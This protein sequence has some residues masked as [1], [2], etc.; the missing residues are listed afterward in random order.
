MTTFALVPGAGGEAVYW[1]RV[2]PLL[3]AAG[4]RVVPVDLPADD[5]KAGWHEYADAVVTAV[6]G[7]ASAVGGAA[8]A[9]ELVVVAQSMGG[10]TAPLLATRLPVRELVLVNAMIP[11][12]G[13]TGGQ[14]WAS[15]GQPAAQRESDVRE[16]RDPDA[17]FDPRV[18]FF[19]DVP[20]EITAVAL[21]DARDQSATPF[22]QPWPLEA[23]PDV[24]TRVLSGTD[25]RLFP[26]EFQERVARERL[27]ITPQRLPG[28][29]L[30]ALSHPEE[31]AA[32]LLC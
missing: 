15:T 18:V 6:T 23:W 30:I 16:G 19:H 3:Q 26:V 5:E 13:E 17:S 12:P 27:G 24:P 7:D 4:H 31:L 1:H 25:D 10:F 29:H 11:V 21:T 32:A 28:G 9:G 20:A 22:E 14:W 8:V 2:V